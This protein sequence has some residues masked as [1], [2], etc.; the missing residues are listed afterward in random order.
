M[1]WSPTS[2]PRVIDC[3]LCNDKK[4]QSN[5]G[6][7]R[8]V[9]TLHCT[10]PFPPYLPLSVD[11]S[12]SHLKHRSYPRTNLTHHPR[13]H[14]D[15]VWSFTKID[16]HYQR[17]DGQ[18]DRTNT[19]LDLCQMAAYAISDQGRNHRS[20]VGATSVQKASTARRRRRRVVG[21]GER[22]FPSPAD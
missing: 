21:N 3:M 14:L 7:D 16:G 18:T 4:S 8:V 6:R 12:G 9:H 20:K 17:M 22:V 10:V 1:R 19:E 11:G 5:T 2:K 15:R 13:R